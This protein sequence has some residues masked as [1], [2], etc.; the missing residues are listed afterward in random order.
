MF[1]V[2]GFFFKSSWKK[3][4]L[5][6]VSSAATAGMNLLAFKYLSEIITEPDSNYLQLI[7]F[8]AL[9]VIVSSLITLFV[10]KYI[11][12]HF[13]LK[14]ADYRKDLTQRVLQ[15]NYQTI[16]KKLDRLVAVLLFEVSSVGN[17]GKLIPEKWS[18]W[19]P[20]TNKI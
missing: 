5:A 8:I 13:E 19:N 10:G 9:L 18:G 16:E 17:F 7:L 1:R 15:V 2:I 11:T 3:I 6:S 12:R 14:V 4:L 20:S